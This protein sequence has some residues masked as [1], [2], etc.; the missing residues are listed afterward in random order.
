M[1]ALARRLDVAPNALYS[2]VADKTDLLDQLLDEAGAGL[3][4]RAAAGSWF[5]AARSS[6]G[7]AS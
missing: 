2:H 4:W 3:T 5:Q 1:R 6:A 7:P